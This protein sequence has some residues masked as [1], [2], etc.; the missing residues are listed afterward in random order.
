MGIFAIP[1]WDQVALSPQLMLH[2]TEKFLES[3]SKFISNYSHKDRFSKEN[4]KKAII[5]RNRWGEVWDFF[6]VDAYQRSSLALRFT[7]PNFIANIRSYV[8][9][10][11]SLAAGT[12]ALEEVRDL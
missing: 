9:R 12:K 7:S 1:I 10:W 11:E 2:Q 3:V 5:L 8:Q 6:G 4:V